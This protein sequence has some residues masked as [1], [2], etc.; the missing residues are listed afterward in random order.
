MGAVRTM[1][2]A[3][4]QG[5]VVAIFPE[6]GINDYRQEH[7]HPGIGYLALKTGVP[8][9]PASITWEIPR[10]LTLGRSL[11]TPGYARVRYGAPVELEFVAKPDR[12]NIQLATD[13]I[14]RAIRELRNLES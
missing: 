10:P 4:K 1:L 3:L 7:G 8:V 12:K 6:G 14:M 13:K 2:R 11:V 9:T 5:E